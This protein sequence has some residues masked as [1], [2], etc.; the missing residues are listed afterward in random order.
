M[1]LVSKFEECGVQVSKS[2]P[3]ASAQE[4]D[5]P[6]DIVRS[7]H[8]FR[9]GFHISTYQ[10]FN[11]PPPSLSSCLREYTDRHTEY[12]TKLGWHRRPYYLT[13][14]CHHRGP[15]CPGLRP[16]TRKL[17]PARPHLRAN[18]LP[19]TPFVLALRGR[20]TLSVFSRPSPSRRP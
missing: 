11:L 16:S 6:A 20:C 13:L 15:A 18:A 17:I 10:L 2:R 7:N 12:S 9:Y 3:E 1:G 8:P 14:R 4:R 19:S 5:R